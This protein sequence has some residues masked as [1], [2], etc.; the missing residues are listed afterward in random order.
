MKLKTIYS[1]VL[2]A[3]C[4]SFMPLAGMAQD[5][6]IGT[7]YRSEGG[8][9]IETNRMFAAGA[10]VGIDYG[11]MGVKVVARLT[12]KFAF[13]AGIG[14]RAVPLS[15][16]I[17]IL[18]DDFKEELKQLGVPFNNKT[19]TGLS[20]HIGMD[21]WQKNVYVSWQFIQY[22]RWTSLYDYTARKSLYGYN[23]SV[24]GFI[25]IKKLPLAIDVGG[26]FGMGFGNDITL[27]TITGDGLVPAIFM[28]V[29][30]G[31]V[32]THNY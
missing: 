32:F 30:L 13:S 19:L 24:G 20:Y 5:R 29:H 7:G 26:S 18:G 17:M 1:F 22:G 31:V 23:M 15:L 16:P 11:N 10:G 8:E 27:E 2:V 28:G 3:A 14:S 4:L 21:I 12:P 6:E 9:L 25:P